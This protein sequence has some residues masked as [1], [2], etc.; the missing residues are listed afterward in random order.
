MSTI[1]EMIETEDQA[2]AVRALGVGYGQG[3]LFGHP[4]AQ[5]VTAGPKSV[6]ARRV[7]AVEGWS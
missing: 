1:A 4:A 6:K 2:T 7:G 5:P 3:W